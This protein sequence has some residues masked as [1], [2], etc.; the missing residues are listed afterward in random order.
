MNDKSMR[1][2]LLVLSDG[3]FRKQLI[4]LSEVT[5]RIYK[6]TPLI[7]AQLEEQ[8]DRFMRFKDLLVDLTALMEESEERMDVLEKKVGNIR[9]GQ[10]EDDLYDLLRKKLNQYKEDRLFKG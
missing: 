7:Y 9:A 2:Y 10:L 8:D 5:G 4:D 3:Q 6:G 1:E